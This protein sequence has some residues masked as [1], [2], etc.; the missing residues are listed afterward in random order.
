[1]V[2]RSLEPCYN[3]ETAGEPKTDKVSLQYVDS[4]ITHVLVVVADEDDS[5]LFNGR[6]R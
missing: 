5:H 1:M 6:R 3:V 2:S 4:K